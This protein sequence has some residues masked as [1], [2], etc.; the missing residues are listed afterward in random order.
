L[1]ADLLAIV[2]QSFD[3]AALKERADLLEIDRSLQSELT[4]KGKSST[5]PVPASSRLR[6]SR[7]AT[8]NGG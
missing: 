1:P 5:S 6:S 8:R 4:E 3:A 7:Q 2:N